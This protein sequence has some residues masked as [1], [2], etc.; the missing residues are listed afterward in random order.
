MSQPTTLAPGFNPHAIHHFTNGNALKS[1]P[2]PAQPSQYPRHI[3]SS[4]YTSGVP[5]HMQT[6]RQSS[7]TSGVIH[8]PEPRR[9]IALASPQQSSNSTNQ[10]QPKPI[11]TT[12]QQDR[13]SPELEEILL[14]K[15]LTQVL[16]PTALGHNAYS[17]S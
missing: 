8:S 14:R 3:A 4:Q 13:A 11:F 17:S 12:F 16:G 6:P 2:P 7:T 1:Y 15:K 9:P 5:A 10:R